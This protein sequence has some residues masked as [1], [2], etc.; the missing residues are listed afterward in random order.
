MPTLFHVDEHTYEFDS[1]KP[2][3]PSLHVYGAAY[4][5]PPQH[6]TEVSAYLDIRE[7]NGYSIQYT[8]F[9]P[10]GASPGSSSP[11]RNCLVYI[12]LPTNPQF[13]GV[14]DPRDVAEV[15]GANRGPSGE[16]AE[17]LF[18]LE[19][20][21]NGLGEGS[22]DEHVEDLADRVRSLQTTVWR[23]R[24]GATITDEA[25]N[26]EVEKVISRSQGSLGPRDVTEE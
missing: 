7:I 5:I 23:E 14:Q 26:N 22:R 18:M 4:R 6:V 15:I 2:N 1:G 9:Y 25:I 12:G 19:E 24:D 8:D 21:L 10:A 11:I 20:A 17:Y 3:L 13:L 16:N